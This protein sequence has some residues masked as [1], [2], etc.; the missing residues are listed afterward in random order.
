MFSTKVNPGSTKRS[1]LTQ[2]RGYRPKII[3]NFHL[4]WYLMVEYGLSICCVTIVITIKNW[5]IILLPFISK[6]ITGWWFQ[7]LWKI[8]KSVGIIIPN[9]WKVIKIPWFQATN[10]IISTI[11]WN[12]TPRCIPSHGTSPMG[13]RTIGKATTDTVTGL[14]DWLVN[15]IYHSIACKIDSW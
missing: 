13:P 10:Q 15:H 9:I 14:A 1:W 7:P 3:C 8:W 6:S 11:S 4:N 2:L 5:D 12:C